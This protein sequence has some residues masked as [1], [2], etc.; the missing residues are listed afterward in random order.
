MPRSVWLRRDGDRVDFT[1]DSTLNISSLVAPVPAV[2][3]HA[4][5]GGSELSFEELFRRHY[6]VIREHLEGHRAPGLALIVIGAAGVEAKAWVAAETDVANPIIVGRHSAAEIFLPSDPSL[7]LRHLALIL[8]RP[9][10]LHWTPEVLGALAFLGVVNAGIAY[11][12]YVVLI[13]KGGPTFAIVCNPFARVTDTPEAACSAGVASIGGGISARIS[14]VASRSRSA[15]GS[16]AIIAATCCASPCPAAAPVAADRA[17]A[18]SHSRSASTR[19]ML[20]P[21]GATR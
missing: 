5:L 19:S 21:S 14:A 11:L 16:A 3:R 15:G 18:R 12:L 4:P 9:W 1:N 20:L 13:A 2:E 10:T 7:S 8:D 17:S 6:P